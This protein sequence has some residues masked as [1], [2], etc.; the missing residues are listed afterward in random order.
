[1]LNHPPS[2]WNL[3][4]IYW[5]IS[6][7]ATI[8]GM[9]ISIVIFSLSPLFLNYLINSG[10][11]ESFK[12]QFFN[13]LPFSGHESLI[14]NPSP[15]MIFYSNFLIF[16]G[17]YL[18]YFY[19]F[20]RILNLN[21]YPNFLRTAVL[22]SHYNKIFLFPLFIYSFLDLRLLSSSGSP[23]GSFIGFSLVMLVTYYCLLFIKLRKF[24]STI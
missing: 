12:G 21:L 9:T 14:K 5:S 11:L 19:G 1:M 18:L 16:L 7:R 23:Y 13:F 8:L 22:F 6:W 24:I 17:D 20:K 4:K 10:N 3:I 15:L 2:L